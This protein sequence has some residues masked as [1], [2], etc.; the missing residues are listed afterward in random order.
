MHLVAFLPVAIRAQSLSIFGFGQATFAVR[1]NMVCVP[2][3]FQ[4]ASTLRVTAFAVRFEKQRGP[5]TVVKKP[6]AI[7][8]FISNNSPTDSC[9]PNA[10]RGRYIGVMPSG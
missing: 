9:A 7:P 10:H 8:H 3:G 1:L 5:F 6:T 2:T 4:L